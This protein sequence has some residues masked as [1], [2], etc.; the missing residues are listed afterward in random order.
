MWAAERR[1]SFDSTPFRS[2]CMRRVVDAKRPKPYPT[3]CVGGPPSA[4]AMRRTWA[5]RGYENPKSTAWTKRPA[6]VGRLRVWRRREFHSLK[7]I[8]F[9]SINRDFCRAAGAAQGPLHIGRWTQPLSLL[10]WSPL[11]GPCQMLILLANSSGH[12]WRVPAAGRP[13]GIAPTR[14]AI[15]QQYQCFPQRL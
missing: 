2:G 10:T 12:A 5:N 8:L 9:I 1:I 7:N 14:W 4:A 11:Y 3:P 15:R 6:D 13:R